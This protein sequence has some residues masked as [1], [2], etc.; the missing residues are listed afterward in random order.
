MK[1][2]RAVIYPPGYDLRLVLRVEAAVGGA[3]IHVVNRVREHY[4]A[5]CLAG[6]FDEAAACE[7]ELRAM[8]P[9][10]HVFVGRTM[11]TRAGQFCRVLHVLAAIRVVEFQDLFVLACRPDEVAPISWS[12]PPELSCSSCGD[13]G[14]H[15]S[16]SGGQCSVCRGGRQ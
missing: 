4:H 13:M 10:T 15:L 11:P 9:V 3:R 8:L 1:L 16:L 7:R 12:A 14:Q 6:R 2:N 5:H